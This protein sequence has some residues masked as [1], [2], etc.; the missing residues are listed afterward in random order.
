LKDTDCVRFLQWALP[1]LG[2]RWQGFRRVRR[3]VCRRLRH[4][5]SDLQM[6]SVAQYQ[7][8]LECGLA[9]TEWAGLDRLCRISISRFYRDKRVFQ[10]LEQELLPRLQHQVLARNDRP[11]RIWCIG[12]A[13]GE[14]PYTLA[15]MSRFTPSLS[16][17]SLYIVATDADTHL[18]TRA[19]RACYPASSLRE[20]PNP[21]RVAFDIRNGEFCLQSKY[22]EAVSFSE[23][24]IRQ[25]SADGVF[26]LI[27]CRNLV[28][29]YFV[30]ALQI[31]IAR[32][33]AD[34]MLPGGLLLL[35]AH[36]TLPEPLP[37]L[38]AESAWLYRRVVEQNVDNT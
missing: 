17:R 26:D 28:F 12:C 8:L 16:H 22:R 32:R 33:L 37:A 10:R 38:E 19:R 3:Q 14:E 6:D 23:Q 18:L 15:L 5:L 11:L 7:S 27:L 31:E 13:S 1:R 30:P 34:V 24:D 9:E 25:Q 35:G 21:W 4:R 29:T 36:E 20:L 2:M